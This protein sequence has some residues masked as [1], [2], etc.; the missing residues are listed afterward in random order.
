MR[1]VAPLW[2]VLVVLLA[3]C[4]GGNGGGSDS[5]AEGGCGPDTEEPLDP[6]SLT[7]LLPGAPEPAYATDPP[8][9]GP[10]LAGPAVSG[11]QG[12]ALPRPVQVA[13]LEAG[14]VMVQHTG[15]LPSGDL[16]RLRR[17]A[18]RTV[19]VAPNPDLDSPVVATAWRHRLACGGASGGAL[20]ALE[21]FVEAHEG[22]GPEQD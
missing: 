10:H 8:S 11:V 1:R 18:G 7:H 9:S 6:G 15:D 4:G 19:V 16:R 2:L 3:A 20:D 14:G 21:T 22:K 13:V 17:L 12:E 5:G